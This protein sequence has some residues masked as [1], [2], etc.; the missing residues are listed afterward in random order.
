MQEWAGAKTEPILA[1]QRE[2]GRRRTAFYSI[3]LLFD[4]LEEDIV[5]VEIFAIISFYLQLF[6]RKN[7]YSIQALVHSFL[8]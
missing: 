2:V 3:F 4:C 5:C 1:K 6:E 7:N 8:L